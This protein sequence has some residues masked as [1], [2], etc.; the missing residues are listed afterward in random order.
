M[1]QNITGAGGGNIDDIID[2]DSNWETFTPISVDGANCDLKILQTAKRIYLKGTV[3]T[4]N[5]NPSNI[6]F[7][8]SKYHI[9]RYV[10]IPAASMSGYA[11]RMS[12]IS[13]IEG[14]GKI[15][16]FA[17]NGDTIYADTLVV[18]SWINL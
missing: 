2:N 13:I 11:T 17:R 14:R 15:Q 8:A 12:C 5:Y 16:T 4:C 3:T 9:P 6:E 7:D 10:Y 18:D 1:I